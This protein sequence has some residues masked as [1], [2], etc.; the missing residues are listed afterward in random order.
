MKL[1]NLRALDN[2]FVNTAKEFQ[3]QAQ[4]STVMKPFLAMLTD[5]DEDLTKVGELSTALVNTR[6]FELAAQHLKSEPASATLIE[7]RYLAPPHDL[8]FLLK[9]PKESLGYIY[10]STMKKQKFDP[11]LYSY[12]KVDSDASYVEARLSQT[13]D[14][15]HTIT[16]FDSSGIGEIG[17]QAFHL[18]QFPYPLAT[19]LIANSLVSATLLAPEELPKL[20]N[21]IAR[22]W[23][24][25]TQVKS[26]FNQKWEEA[27]EKP[28]KQWRSELNV[29][30]ITVS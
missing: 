21:A 30:S 2:F 6:A 23:Q 1:F 10:A 12:L 24:M 13:H 9:Y 8:N 15:W 11:D 5:E 22:G 26:F 18:P 25:G 28:L 27:W 19:M 29:Q 17:L 7:E 4:F 16:G 14:I 3:T 20:L